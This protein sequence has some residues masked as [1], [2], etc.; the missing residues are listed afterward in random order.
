MFEIVSQQSISH[1]LTVKRRNTTR[2]VVVKSLPQQWWEKQFPSSSFPVECW[3]SFYTA[4]WK[5]HAGSSLVAF[6]YE[7]A[8]TAALANPN[9][10]DRNKWEA[11]ALYAATQV[12]S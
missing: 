9:K 2:S 11:V 3:E 12:I 8:I 10:F 1:S 4:V 5:G 7:D 6:I